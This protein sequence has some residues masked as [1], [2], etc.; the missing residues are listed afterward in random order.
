MNISFPIPQEF[1]A[2]V[3]SQ[4]QS[5]NYANVADYFLALLH[6]DYQRKK[7][8]EK[9]RELLQEGLES[10]GEAVTSA[11]WQNLRMSVLE[12]QSEI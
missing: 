10:E 1:E 8:Q 3:E 2:Y 11:Y 12:K 5:G 9:L 4:L 7:A 6:Q